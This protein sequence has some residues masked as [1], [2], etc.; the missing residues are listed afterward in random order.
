[1]YCIEQSEQKGKQA[2]KGWDIESLM[3]VDVSIRKPVGFTP[4]VRSFYLN[5]AIKVK[6]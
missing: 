3:N 1:M 4:A 2:K 6:N 5:P